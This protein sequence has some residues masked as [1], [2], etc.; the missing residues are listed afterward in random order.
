MVIMKCW[1]N[2]CKCGKMCE[3][4]NFSFKKWYDFFVFITF[5]VCFFHDKGKF[6]DFL[7]RC[8]KMREFLTFSKKSGMWEKIGIWI[9]KV[10]SWSGPVRS[11][12]SPGPVRFWSD[13]KSLVRSGPTSMSGNNTCYSP[14]TVNPSIEPPSLF[15]PPSEAL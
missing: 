10:N 6:W 4:M 7:P 13:L 3:F 1:K 9:K 11:V 2:N 15:E 14:Y 8:E 5:F 12:A